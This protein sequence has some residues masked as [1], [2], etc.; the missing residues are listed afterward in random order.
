MSVTLFTPLVIVASS[1]GLLFAMVSVARL[2][3]RRGDRRSPLTKEMLRGPAH[4]LREQ[5]DDISWDVAANLAIA[6]LLPVTIYALYLE[7]RLASGAISDVTRGIYFVACLVAVIFVG[8]RMIRLMRRLRDSRLGLEAEVA[9]AEEF[10]RLMQRGYFVFHD[11]PGD[12]PYNV[13]HVLVGPAGVFAVETKGRMKRTHRLSKDGHVVQSDGVALAFPGWTEH[14]PI[15]QAHRNAKWLAKWLSSAVGESII[16][17]PI[18]VLP[19]WFVKRTN[20]TGVLAFNQNEVAGF[21]NQKREAS[22]TEQQI[23]RICHQLDQRCRT[24]ASKVGRPRRQAN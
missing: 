2:W 16:A 7:Q 13:D 23:G 17:H 20:T 19:G 21:L 18:L 11:V 12:G 24:V 10:N 22:L 4:F 1:F 6:P 8:W 3:I 9:A 15:E 14:E 5:I